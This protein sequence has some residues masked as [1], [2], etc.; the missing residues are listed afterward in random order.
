MEPLASLHDV[1]DWIAGFDLSKTTVHAHKYVFI[2]L[3][4]DLKNNNEG[5]DLLWLNHDMSTTILWSSQ[6]IHNKWAG[7]H[8]KR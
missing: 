3:C 6:G 2:A 7:V 8:M 5:L 4:Q 1:I